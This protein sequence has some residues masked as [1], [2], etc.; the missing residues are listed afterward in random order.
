MCLSATPF[1]P[2]NRSVVFSIDKT[3]GNKKS[4]CLGVC[5]QNVVRNI[6]FANCGGGLG[7][8]IYAID[9]NSPYSGDNEMLASWNHHDS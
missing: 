9:Q 6:N 5:L 7:K 2:I 3:E 8:G 1:D 4:I